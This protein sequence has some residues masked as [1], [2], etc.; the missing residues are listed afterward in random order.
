MFNYYYY[1]YSRHSSGRFARRGSGDTSDGNKL[2]IQ[3]LDADMTLTSNLRR[4]T[5]DTTKVRKLSSQV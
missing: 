3:T 2:R 1:Y 5:L 4:C